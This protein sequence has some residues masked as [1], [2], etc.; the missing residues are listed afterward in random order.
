MSTDEF[1]KSRTEKAL[2]HL[3]SLKPNDG[4][5]IDYY[6][7][8]SGDR[9]VMLK[10][11]NVPLT[12]GSGFISLVYDEYET[13]TVVGITKIIGKS[14]SNSYFCLGNVLVEKSGT[15]SRDLR[16]IRV[17][18]DGIN[19]K[20]KDLKESKERMNLNLNMAKNALNEREQHKNLNPSSCRSSDSEE[21]TTELAKI[22]L[23]IIG[24][25]TALRILASFR[26]LLNAIFIPVVILY[27]MQTCPPETSFD[28][29]KEL[30]RVHRGKHLPE[31][32]EN[33]PAND[34]LS[35]AIARVTASV[36]TE[37][38]TALG[39]EVSFVVSH[40]N[41]GAHDLLLRMLIVKPC[42]IYHTS[43]YCRNIR[44]S[45]GTRHDI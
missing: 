32:H 25:L 31:G 41:V 26:L 5:S 30:K 38:A 14:G 8:F 24:L 42:H 18:I 23:M 3:K 43:E 34:W 4:W 13:E 29:K 28:A 36:G 20:Q 22:G 11:R 19:T 33:K 2:A 10:R 39:Y 12:K 6:V 45:Y 35:Q 27:A 17:K 7:G 44:Y 9:V 1:L 40:I 16:E 37:L 15:V 21:D